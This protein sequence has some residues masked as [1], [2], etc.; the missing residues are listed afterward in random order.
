MADFTREPLAFPSPHPSL[1]CG[2]KNFSIPKH[3][4]FTAGSLRLQ[5]LLI[6][7]Q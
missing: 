3:S 4:R 2:T 5:Q 7:P 6:S 1:L